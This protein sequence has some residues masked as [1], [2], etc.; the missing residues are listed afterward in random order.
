MN[1]EDMI[2]HCLDTRELQIVLHQRYILVIAKYIL[3]ESSSVI[4]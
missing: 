2:R 1:C 4:E 3:K